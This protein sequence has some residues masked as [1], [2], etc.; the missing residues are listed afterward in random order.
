MP[1]SSDSDRRTISDASRPPAAAAATPWSRMG[2]IAGGPALLVGLLVMLFSWPAAESGPRDV[3]IVVVGTQESAAGLEADLEAAVPDGFDVEEVTD[4]ERARSL[5]ADRDVYGALTV[6]PDGSVGAMTAPAG[7]PAV[8]ELLRGVADYLSDAST[9]AQSA[10]VEKVVPLPVDDPRGSGFTATVLPLMIGG[11]VIGIA[12][13]FLVTGVARRMLAVALAAVAAGVSTCLVTHTWL[14]ILE[15]SFWASAGAISL[16][17]GAVAATIAGLTSRIGPP[18]IG[19]GAVV[20][21]LFGNSLSGVASSPALLPEGW[22][23]VGQLL[24]PGATGS[25]LR[26][27]AYF[28]G[29]AGLG[30]ALVLACWVALGTLVAAFSARSALSG[31]QAL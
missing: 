28:D 16:G 31:D 19:L 17:I 26:S 23:T 27:V 4:R 13:S 11:M 8:A 7:G 6:E 18:G 9:G 14:G 10:P 22:A 1:D 12:M 25:L 15:G 3:P 30:P 24:P 29:A 20:M 5:I 21:F 2:L